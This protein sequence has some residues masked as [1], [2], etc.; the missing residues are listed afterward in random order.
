MWDEVDGVFGERTRR[1]IREWQREKGME[2]TGYVTR[3]QAEALKELGAARRA[4]LA[5]EAEARRQAE[6][7]RLQRE[8]EA[9]ERKRRE[10]EE[11]ARRAAEMRPGREFRACKRVVVS[12]AGG[13]TCGGVHAG[14]SRR[15]RE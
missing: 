7:G 10:R 3:E 9:A 2:V 12:G 15:G 5:Q 1:A 4:R 11:A 6:L 13:G 14:V 8:R